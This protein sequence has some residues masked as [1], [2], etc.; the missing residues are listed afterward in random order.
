MYR[1]CTF[2]ANPV[3]IQASGF[4][5]DSLLHSEQQLH[6]ST[7][8]IL[9][10]TTLVML[11]SLPMSEAVGIQ[12]LRDRYG[13]RLSPQTYPPR[14]KNETFDDYCFIVQTSCRETEER[15]AEV[16][17][18][19]KDDILT[20]LDKA[21]N[22]SFSLV[23]Y[24]KDAKVI[25]PWSSEVEKIKEV[26][27]ETKNEECTDCQAL[28]YK[29]LDA[30]RKLFKNKDKNGFSDHIII[31]T[32]GITRGDFYT[33]INEVKTKTMNAALEIQR[34]GSIN[35]QVVRIPPTKSNI[36][37]ASGVDEWSILPRIAHVGQHDYHPEL[38]PCSNLGV[39]KDQTINIHLLYGTGQPCCAAADVVFILDK[40]NSIKTKDIVLLLDFFKN[41]LNVQ[42]TILEPAMLNRT[43]G[44][45]IALLT[46][47]GKVTI[48]SKLGQHGKTD[49]IK[50]VKKISTR[51]TKFTS[52]HIA[53][54]K[55]LEQLKTS[56]RECKKTV[57]IATD[58]RTWKPKQ[59]AVDSGEDT[60]KAAKKLKDYGAELRIVGLP[61]NNN[62]IDGYE[63]E[64][65]HMASEPI[66][67]TIVDMQRPSE[68]GSFEDL[69]LVNLYLTEQICSDKP[70][71]CEYN[72]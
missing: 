14:C 49:L 27:G 56:K 46:Y 15:R 1:I 44:L 54:E 11:C 71:P 30:C 48:H 23:T 8:S 72:E 38:I 35:I 64:W 19:V 24:S 36:I 61:N 32:D 34:E 45:Q 29:A 5:Q 53:L 12:S 55:A 62:I 41:Y 69:D 57:V 40:S 47:G 33:D 50:I 28:T 7:M 3:C 63:R 26:W 42:K 51:T 37:D 68:N 52:T 2:G 16:L 43:E 65:K 31:F 17:K 67:C 20:I 70:T 25:L 10:I 60:I 22:P 4:I 58:G 18:S 9:I 66:G 21:A 59:R 13:V 39:N 6:L